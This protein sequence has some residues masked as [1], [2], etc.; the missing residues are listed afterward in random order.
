MENMNLP[1]WTFTEVWNSSF[2][3]RERKAEPRDYLWATDLGKSD[4]D[5]YLQLKGVKPTNAPNSRATRK[6]EAGNIWEN[7]VQV[8]LLRAGILIEEQKHVRHQYDGLLEVTGRV[9]FIAGGDIDWK[10]ALDVINGDEF[11]FLPEATRNASKTVIDNLALNHPEGLKKIV[12]E[13][14]SCSAN[15]FDVYLNTGKASINHELQSFHYLKSTGID[16]A[17]IVY[18]S[19]D[20]VRMLNIPIWL[21]DS[22]LEEKYK[23]K[24]QSLTNY[25][26]KGV[27]PDKEKVIVFDENRGRFVANWRVTYSNYLTML[28][29][30][31]DETEVGDYARPLQDKWNR[32]LTRVVEGKDMT[33]LNSSVIEDWKVEFGEKSVEK[34]IEIAK[35][36]KKEKEVEETVDII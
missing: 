12:L 25:Y 6:F 15:M 14:K 27:Q 1:S 20:D 11:S 9:D 28:Y 21:N 23:S 5:V 2:E 30:F 7:I 17:H 16:E 19:K 3:P 35:S 13:I 10:K 34:F 18:I 26:N 22:S 29:G 36:V 33:K 32:T 24:I 8:M 31:K 4:I